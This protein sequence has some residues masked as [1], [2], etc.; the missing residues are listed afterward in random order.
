MTTAAN[1]S[2][3]VPYPDIPNMSDGVYSAP[4]GTGHAVLGRTLPSL[5][6]EACRNNPN[7]RAFNQFREGVWHPL[8]TED[9]RTQAEAVALGLTDLGLKKGDRVGFYTHSDLSFCLMDMACLIAGFVSVPIYLT[10]TGETTAFI[11]EETEAK[12]LAVSDAALLGEVAPLLDKLPKLETLLIYNT[13]HNTAEVNADLGKPLYSYDDIQARGA[14]LR[15]RNADAVKTLRTEVQADDLATIIYT[16]G[17]TGTPKGVMLSHEN[18]SSN[19]VAAFSGIHELRRGEEV[20]LSFLP[21]THVFARTLHYGYLAWGVAVYFTTPDRVGEH[22]RDVEPTVFST[23]P[24]VLEKV[25]E[26]ILSAGHALSGAKKQL[27]DWALELARRYRVGEAPGSLYNL[28]LRAADRLV[29]ARWRA[30]LGGEMRLVIVGGAALRPELVHLFGAVGVNVLQGYGLTETSPIITYNR[31]EANRAGTVGQVLAG[32]EIK[33]SNKG[34]VL[35]RGPHVMKGYYNHPEATNKAIDEDG[36]FHTG[37]LGEIDEDG[38]LKITGRLKNLFKLS[39]GKYVMPQPLEGMLEAD[40]L[41]ETALVVG[42]GEKYT[43]ALLFLSQDQLRGFARRSNLDLD[44][45]DLL[46]SDVLHTH[47]Q[48]AV[49]RANRDLPH[50]SHIKRVALIPESLTLEAGLLTPTLKVKRQEVMKRYKAQLDTLFNHDETFDK[51]RRKKDGEEHSQ[52]PHRAGAIIEIETLHAP[53]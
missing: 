31:P 41:I 1:A 39:T 36:W 24:R 21:L 11:L 34:E 45:S 7:A 22:L 16:S 3:S 48:E 13:T 43:A 44:I 25:Y 30:A 42:E 33:L 5:L 52:T 6:N 53:A 9:F 4:E 28:Q 19:A 27:F 46:T 26:R 10:H 8:S 23:V 47:I 35:T 17:T 20:A 14:P 2:T 37:D 51:K 18:L 15:R 12:A 38:F 32:V 50:W 40:D 29:L 49:A